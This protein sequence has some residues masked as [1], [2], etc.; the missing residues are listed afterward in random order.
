MADA[1]CGG[2]I[3]V[4]RRI[5]E[6]KDS[7][8]GSGFGRPA[9]GVILCS[10]DLHT[11]FGACLEVA[12][13]RGNRKHLNGAQQNA[14]P[15]PA[16]AQPMNGAQAWRNGLVNPTDIVNPEARRWSGSTAMSNDISGADFSNAQQA[17]VP[18]SICEFSPNFLYREWNR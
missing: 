10:Y 9:E 5:M 14:T 16:Q 1:V 15:A 7:L 13:L 6:R 18:H 17:H 11:Y 12:N 4:W 2:G 3:A 8:R